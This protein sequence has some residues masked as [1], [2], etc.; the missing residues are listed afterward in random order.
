MRTTIAGSQIHLYSD[1]SGYQEEI[2]AKWQRDADGK[3]IVTC[4][5]IK[6]G[7]SRL[8]ITFVEWAAVREAVD[9]AIADTGWAA[10]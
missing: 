7:D 5:E 1:N 6:Q 10:R 2:E 8:V 9:N 4:V 3:D